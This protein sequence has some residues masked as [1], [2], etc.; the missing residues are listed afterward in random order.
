MESRLDS[1]P[2]PSGPENSLSGVPVEIL[3]KIIKDVDL[4]G[5]ASLAKVNQH[6]NFVTIPILRSCESCG[7]VDE[8][9]TRDKTGG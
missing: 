9:V 8:G 1:R 7:V 2:A 5:L 3:V 6:L 4:K